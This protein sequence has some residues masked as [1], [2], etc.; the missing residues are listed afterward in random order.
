LAGL[1][2]QLFNARLDAAV[3]ALFLIAVAIIVFGSAIEWWK[4]LGG[5]K[6]AVL[7]ESQFVALPDEA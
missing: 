6:P 7:R 1:E 5:R 3:A 4:L 2:R